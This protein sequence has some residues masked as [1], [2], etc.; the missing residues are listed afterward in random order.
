MKKPTVRL[1]RGSV[2]V[3]V[4][5]ACAGLVGTGLA[6]A[7]GTSAQADG[8]VTPATPIQHLV[9]IYDENV[10]YDHYF[11]TYPKATN[12]DGT[13][14]TASKSTPSNNNLARAGLLG[15]ANPNS[16]APF[17]L[18]PSQAVT[19]DQNHNYTPEQSAVNNGK[20]DLFVESVSTNANCNSSATYGTDGLT[21]G[22][23]DGNTVTAMWNY[24]QHY[25]MSDNS[26]DATFGPSTPGA[27]N[28][29]SGQ[30]HGVISYQP[31]NSTSPVPTVTPDSYTV[32]DPDANGVGTVTADP[33]PVYDDCNNSNHK[34]SNAVGGMQSSNKNIGDLLNSAGVTWGW[35]Q[36][37]FA[38]TTPYDGTNPAVCGKTDTNIKGASSLD[39]SPHHNPFEYYQSTSNP[40]H[41]PGTPGV[42]VGA[43]DP[44]DDTTHT[45]ANHQY[46]LSVFDQAVQA[47][48]L[49]AV[50]FVKAA[51]YQ[52]GHASYSDPI[53]E[54]HFLVHTINELEQSPQWSS[55]AVVIAYDD[56]DGWYDHVAPKIT[57]GSSSTTNDL[58]IC[59]AA[60][61]NPA[62]AALT[63]SGSRS[64]TSGYLDRCGPSQR[65]P[66]L[67]ISPWA[68]SDYIDHRVTNQA[69]I[70]KFIEQNWLSSTN[71]TTGATTVQTIG[72]GSFDA[73]AGSIMPMFDFSSAK[74]PNAKPVILNADGSVHKGNST[75]RATLGK[76]ARGRL[77]ITVTVSPSS[78]TGTVKVTV[79][80]RNVGTVTLRG[81]KAG[82]S[83]A[84]K[85]GRYTVAAT[86]SGDAN[87]NG[88]T[89]RSAGVTVR[90]T[91]TRR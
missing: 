28:L 41:Y 37:G 26:W 5:A 81:G 68:K 33:D 78:A 57:N 31:G 83:V 39:Y 7:G 25:A 24:A 55:T 18:T 46:D 75:L 11:A 48:Q 86:Y 76:V 20:M 4:A 13:K 62:T 35:F 12:T 61:D 84:V 45:G 10:S 23:Y 53:D 44:T 87:Y 66:F 67:V 56:S 64:A 34:S 60:N 2:A 72:D 6:L 51:E 88:S 38:P 69:S 29:V 30:T 54:Q 74:A 82:L 59:K 91:A 79:N 73:T 80:N 40:H 8:S 22:Y 27:L 58:A 63:G 65:L 3:G 47:G 70:T 21:M 89:S 49:P 14:F 85:P 16:V 77:P 9:V 17:R 15:D 43:N 19:C 52:D 36:G 50:S 32:K 42:P 1:S 71:S 90:R